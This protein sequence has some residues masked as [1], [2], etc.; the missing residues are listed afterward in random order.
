MENIRKDKTVKFFISVI[1]LVVIGFTLKE[2]SNIFIPFVIAYLLF[3]AFS[4]LNEILSKFKIPM[5]LI[6]LLDIS[7]TVLIAWGVSA[8]IIGSFS[9]FADQLPLYEEKLNL[10]VKNVSLGL[11]I[12]DPFYNNFS[13]NNLI[14]N[15]DYK[16]IAGNIFTSTFSLLGSVLFVLFFFVFVV[17]GHNNIYEAIKKRFVHRKPDHDLDK[18]KATLNAGINE[19]E[20]DKLERETSEREDKLAG[21]FKNITKQIQRYIIAK[22]G[23]NLGAGISVFIVCLIFK[24]DFPIVWALFTFLFNFI[25]SLGSAIA[26]GLPIVFVLVQT[27]SAG[28]TILIALIIGAIQTLFF[29][30]LEPQL[31][32]RRLNLNPLLILLSVLL[33]GYVWGIIGMLLSVPLTAIIKIIMSNSDSKDMQFFSDLMSKE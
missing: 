32:G 15:L 30:V 17:T 22:I 9:Q 18:A 13:I 2:L 10:I 1:G 8:F 4:P 21:T 3:F 12:K 31:I 28:F 27:G 14:R 20:S 25:P 24:I 26:L 19:T 11:G 5:F 7:I 29:N 16:P 33:W 6:I 23:V